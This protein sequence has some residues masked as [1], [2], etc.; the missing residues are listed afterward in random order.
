[1]D[2]VSVV[3]AQ[4]VGLHLLIEL[5]RPVERFRVDV[6]RIKQPEIILLRRKTPSLQGGDIRR[7]PNMVRCAVRHYFLFDK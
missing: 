1:M 5:Y 4:Q 6:P 7:R 2:K 3:S